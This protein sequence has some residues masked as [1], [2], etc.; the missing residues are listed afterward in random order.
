MLQMNGNFSPAANMAGANGYMHSM[1]QPM[2][3]FP[4]A[5]PNMQAY[6]QQANMFQPG[7]CCA[8]PFMGVAICSH[9]RA[10]RPRLLTK[11]EKKTSPSL[12]AIQARVYYNSKKERD[13]LDAQALHEYYQE[14]NGVR[15]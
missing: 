7:V 9:R 8:A 2:V 15:K 1:Q 14:K 6:M 3:H 12:A 10:D 4:F 11:E 5:F 13:V